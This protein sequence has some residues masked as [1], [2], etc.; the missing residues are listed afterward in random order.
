MEAGV[1]AVQRAIE[2]QPLV[3][4]TR[5]RDD[6]GGPA[7]QQPCHH[8][9]GD[10]TF[11]RT[12][13]HRNFVAVATFSGVLRAGGDARVQR[14]V[15][16]APGRQRLTL[17]PGRLRRHHVAG[18]LEPGG[19]PRPVGVDLVVAGQPQPD[20]VL[21][22]AGPAVVEHHRLTGVENRR[23]QP[24]PVRTE[25][26]AYQVDQFGVGRPRRRSPRVTQ[27]ELVEHQ[28]CGRR[29]HPVAAGDLLCELAQS[30][31]VH[32]PTAATG[33][34]Q[35]HRHAAAGSHRGD[36]GV[37]GP[38]DGGGVGQRTLVQMPQRAAAHAGALPG[39]QRHLDGDVPDPAVAELPGLPHPLDDGPGP[40][41]GRPE[42]R[43]QLVVDRVGQHRP[44]R[45]VGA[46]QLGH[47]RPQP[48]QVGFGRAVDRA[49][50]QLG[51]EV[52]QQLVAPR[53]RP[54]GDRLDGVQLLDLV[55]AHLGRQRDQ[56]A[57]RVGGVERDVVGARST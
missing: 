15:D 49:Q 40:F 30:G 47:L 54:V 43:A 41:P 57:R 16:L 21:A 36:R 45:L 20:Q 12:G 17:P 29:Q 35:R 38:V 50:I 6:H 3:V 51:S 56:R 44:I 28:A 26:G 2:R 9:R 10:R 31:R 27:S 13:H 4:E 18:A 53:R 42:H 48:G 37:D 24:R 25:F 7:V 8:R 32:R 46:C 22:G 52:H 34:R 19:Q 23:D 55:D 5:R 1:V 39:A 14:G 33:R 11:R